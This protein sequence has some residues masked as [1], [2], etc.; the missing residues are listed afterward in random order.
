MAA[1]LLHDLL[2]NVSHLEP[3]S[4]HEEV[5]D[6]PLGFFLIA[7]ALL[8]T[9]PPDCGQFCNAAG[10]AKGDNPVPESN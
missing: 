1:P 3:F 4:D 8:V 10:A 2:P 9:F 6:L 7:P 5:C